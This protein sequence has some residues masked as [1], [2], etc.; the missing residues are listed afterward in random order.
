M[1]KKVQIGQVSEVCRCVE[2]QSRRLAR[3]TFRRTGRNIAARRIIVRLSVGQPGTDDSLGRLI[4]RKGLVGSSKQPIECTSRSLRVRG[5]PRRGVRSCVRSRRGPATGPGGRANMA[6]S[7]VSNVSSVQRKDGTNGHRAGGRKFTGMMKSGSDVQARISRTGTTVLCPP[8]NLDYLVAKPAKDKGAFFIRSVFQFTRTGRIFT[9]SGRLIIFGY[10]SCTRGPRLLVT[11]LFNCHGNTFAKTARAASNLV[12]QT[13]NNVLFV[14]RIRHLPPR[15]RRVVFCLVSRNACG[16]LNRAS[17]TGGIG[18]QLIYTAARSPTSDLLRAFIEH[19]PVIVGLP[20]FSRQPVTRRISLLGQVITV[21]TGHVR[22]DVRIGR[23]TIGTLV[24]DIACKGINRLG[25]GI[26]LI[27]TQT[28]LGCVGSD[29]VS[30]ALSRLA[31]RVRGNL[32]GLTGG[33]HRHLGRL[34]QVLRPILA[35][36][37]GRKARDPVVESSCSLPCGLCRVVKGGTTLLQRRKLSRRS[38]GRFVVAS[39][40]I[41]LG[42][43]CHSANLAF[44][45]R[46]GLSRVVSRQVVNFTG[47]VFRCTR[48]RLSC[49]FRQGFICTVD[50]RVDSFL[51]QV[52]LKRDDHALRT[53]V[54]GVIRSCPGRFSITG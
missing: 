22:E 42:S 18:I 16:H 31:P 25:S 54:G 51:G 35:L 48:G 21:R 36:M 47:G 23:S 20:R 32:V 2:V 43:F 38:V 1:E 4:H 37:P 34:A 53:D 7:R 10:T 12:R 39:V 6:T 28:F 14:S 3:T 13:S 27:Y 29:S 45:A 11:R 9:T 30:V 40:G 49:R 41:R 26:R 44:S 24:N 50:L 52:R 8:G 19:V 15:K 5:R 46:G 17:G 33:R